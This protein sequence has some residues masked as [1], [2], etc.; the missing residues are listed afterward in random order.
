MEKRSNNGRLI[1][2]GKWIEFQKSVCRHNSLRKIRNGGCAQRAL[3]RDGADSTLIKERRLVIA[4]WERTSAA[5]VRKVIRHANAWREQEVWSPRAAPLSPGCGRESWP[6]SRLP[7]AGILNRVSQ[8]LAHMWVEQ[9]LI[10][11]GTKAPELCCNI[12][13]VYRVCELKEVQNV[14][15]R[16]RRRGQVAHDCSQTSVGSWLAQKHSTVLREGGG[17]PRGH[18]T[19]WDNVLQP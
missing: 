19:R 4:L 5:T 12:S 11:S 8:R 14:K 10:K 1:N 9:L 16:P 3:R 13:T 7:R 17:G 18:A 6:G 2:W 15:S